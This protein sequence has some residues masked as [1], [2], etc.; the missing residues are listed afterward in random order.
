MQAERLS[1]AARLTKLQ[2]AQSKLQEAL[3]INPK[4]SFALNAL[5]LTFKSEIEVRRTLAKT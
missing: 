1:G 4:S 2:E 3:T 5:E